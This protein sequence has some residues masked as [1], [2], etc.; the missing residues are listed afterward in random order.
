[1]KNITLPDYLISKI[2]LYN[3]HDCSTIIIYWNYYIS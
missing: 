2:L 3:S 1:M